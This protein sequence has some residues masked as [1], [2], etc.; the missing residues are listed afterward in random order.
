[1]SQ[2]RRQ[3]LMSRVVNDEIV[4]LDRAAGRVHRF[5]PTATYIWHACDGLSASEIA[6]RMA[7]DF[8]VAPEMVLD[9]IKATLSDFRQLGLVVDGCGEATKVT[10]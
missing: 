7:Q 3:D 4:I 10:G 6:V 8:D 2:R 5:N 9:D 1:M